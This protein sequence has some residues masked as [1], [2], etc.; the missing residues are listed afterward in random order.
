MKILTNLIHEE[1]KQQYQLYQYHS[2][3]YKEIQKGIYGLPQDGVLANKLFKRPIAQKGY[4]EMLFTSGLCT[5]IYQLI[6]FILVI[7]DFSVKDV[8]ANHLIHTLK[9]TTQ[10][11]TACAT[12]FPHMELTTMHTWHIYATIH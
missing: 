7:Y 6:S 11:L 1:I 12:A 8:D 10:W 9:N 3:L 2:F 5:H 4:V